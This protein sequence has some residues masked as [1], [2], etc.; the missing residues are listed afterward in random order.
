[1]L[2]ESDVGVS[3]CPG[4]QKYPWGLLTRT[5]VEWKVPKDEGQKGQYVLS[6]PGLNNTLFRFNDRGQ[7][8]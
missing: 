8:F 2:E 4:S 7:M 1:M 6:H 3:E 5:I